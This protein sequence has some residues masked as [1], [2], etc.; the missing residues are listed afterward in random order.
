M[1]DNK[2]IIRISQK[3]RTTRLQKNMTMQQLAAKSNITKGLISRIENGRTVPSLPVFVNLLQAL[4]I[5]FKTFFEDMILSEGR[6]YILIKRADTELIE[7]E[8]RTGFEYHHILSHTVSSCTMEVALLTIDPEAKCIPTVTDGFELKH[9]LS[10][11]C[12]YM[13]GKEM[14]QLQAGDTLYFDASIPHS[15]VNTGNEGVLMLV[16]YFLFAN[17]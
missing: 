13:I 3:I 16:V 11:E 9:I 12:D 4:G 7:K 1:I 6:N 5:P 14:L 15:P 17:N 8:G 10:G 2:I